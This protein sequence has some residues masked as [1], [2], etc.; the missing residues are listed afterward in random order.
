V[1]RRIQGIS[2]SRYVLQ[3][4]QGSD[5]VR[6]VRPREAE[7]GE[8][9]PN[10]LAETEPFPGEWVTAY[11]FASIRSVRLASGER[12]ALGPH[13]E[14]FTEFKLAAMRAGPWDR[15]PWLGGTEPRLPP[16]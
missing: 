13:G 15:V 2:G 9:D 6:Y 3:P 16:A 12:F 11:D 1:W 8:P 10:R 7:S 14:W 4:C 5:R